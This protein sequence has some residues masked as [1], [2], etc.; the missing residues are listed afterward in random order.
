MDPQGA[1][2]LGTSFA[3]LCSS[4]PGVAYTSECFPC[5]PGTYADEQG[6]S[7]CKLCPENSYSNKEETSCHQCDADKYSGDVSEGRKGLEGDTEHR[8]K[9][10]VEPSFWSSPD[11]P[12]LNPCFLDTG[13]TLPTH[14][15]PIA[16]EIKM[17]SFNRY[18]L[19]FYYLPGPILSAWN[20]LMNKIDK[21]PCL[22]GIYMLERVRQTINNNYNK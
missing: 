19:S 6:S 18:S 4:F 3:F 9:Q 22:H 1:Q 12:F 14:I 20:I 21:V 2:S 7:F 10:A 15:L 8:E 13:R 11:R 17:K 5:K 16:P